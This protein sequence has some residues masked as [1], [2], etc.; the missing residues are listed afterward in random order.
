[1]ELAFQVGP[2]NTHLIPV[3]TNA[4]AR[5]DGFGTFTVRPYP[6]ISGQEIEGG[7]LVLV[8]R[9]HFTWQVTRYQ[10]GAYAVDTAPEK[11]DP[12]IDELGLTT[13]ILEILGGVDRLA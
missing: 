8:Y 5:Y 4:P 3:T 13:A 1:M 7:R 9:E 11:E 6:Y 10:S 12:A 2:I